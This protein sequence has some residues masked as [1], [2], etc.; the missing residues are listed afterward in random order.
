VGSACSYPKE[1]QLNKGLNYF[2]ENDIY[3]LSPE[4]SYG[5][6]KYLGEY[7]A[8]LILNDKNRN[9]NIGILRFHNVYGPYCSY[10]INP[11]VI[12]ALIKKIIYNKDSNLEVWGTGKQYRDFVYIDDIVE[13]LKLVYIS[14][15]NKGVIQIGSGDATTIKE[16]CNKLLLLNNKYLKKNIKLKFDPTKLEGDFGRLSIN[17]KAKNILNWNISTKI[18]TGLENTF[19]WMLNNIEHKYIITSPLDS[20]PTRE[21]F[22]NTSKG[23]LTGVTTNGSFRNEKHTGCGNVMFQI[24]CVSALAWDNNYIATFPVIK[25]FYEILKHK[26]F[27]NDN[28]YRNVNTFNINIKKS[29]GVKQGY[30]KIKLTNNLEIKS[31]F[32]CYKY[33]HKYRDRILDMFSIDSNSMKYIDNKYDIFNKDNINISIHI[34]RGDFVV[35]AN[36][37]NKDYLLD[38][39]YYYNSLNYIDKKINN[40]NLL[41][42]SDDIEYCKKNLNFESKNR[43]VYFMENNLDYIDLWMMSLCNHNII[44][45][46]TFSWW[47]AY[48][49]KNN[50]KIVIA[51]K[52]NIFLEKKNKKELI[53]S[54]YFDNWIIIH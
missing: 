28:I 5:M 47:G 4:T 9:L 35:I 46:S 54:F 41:I 19:V 53:K 12:P 18:D 23:G 31:Y 25:D 26:K 39:S 6:S 22:S 14:G 2:S 49:N 38:D 48:L 13:A 11:Q 10:N 34:R 30:H 16:L 52:T 15:M 37:W 3:P 7:E 50:D 33:F 27:K 45:K 40:Y 1:K 29:I 32:N 21:N 51:P 8:K 24:A 17:D 36:T 42:F 43:K 44:N 20:I